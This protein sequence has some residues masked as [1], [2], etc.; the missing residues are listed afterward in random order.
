MIKKYLRQQFI[1]AACII[2][3]ELTIRTLENEETRSLA[4]GTLLSNQ[5][6]DLQSKNINDY[7]FKIFSQHGDDGIIQYLIKHLDI[8]NKTFIEFGVEDFSESN[9]R[10]LM[11]N[12]NWSGFVID[13]SKEN[14]NR[15]KSYPWYWKYDIRCEAAFIDRENIN[16][17][18]KKS[19]FEN[20]GIL[21]ID[22]D[23]ND[24]YIL[25]EIDFTTLNPAILI[26][27]YNSIFGN[28]RS[29]SIPYDKN[30]SRTHAHYSNLFF[31]ASLPALY[32]QATTKGYVLVGCTLSGNNAFFVRKDL[33]NEKIEKK[34]L[35][36]AFIDSKFRESRDH[37]YKLS[38]LR[39]EQRL[40]AIKGMKVYNVITNQ[41][42]EL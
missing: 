32:H 41:L 1:K 23:G 9:T 4:L 42:E 11:M 2:S 26:L 8:P 13:G 36:N 19:G 22:L 35:Q 10:F 16:L 18:L 17:I 34:S 3:D 24:Y 31:G 27:E 40:A 21:N 6:Y 29:I 30:F 7:E 33:M 12:N 15:L 14:V 39:G 37:N 38:Y 5:Q 28:E 20:I 25:K